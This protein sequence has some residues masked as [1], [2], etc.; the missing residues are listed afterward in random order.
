MTTYTNQT[1]RR[2]ATF[3]YNNGVKPVMELRLSVLVFLLL[4]TYISIIV[5][6]LQAEYPRNARAYGNSIG[7]ML[8]AMERTNTTN[9]RL[10][11]PTKITTLRST[12]RTLRLSYRNP[13]M[14]ILN[15]STNKLILSALTEQLIELMDCFERFTALQHNIDIAV[16]S[17]RLSDVRQRIRNNGSW[18]SIHDL[19]LYDANDN[20]VL[21]R[22]VIMMAVAIAGHP[23]RL[24]GRSLCPRK[25]ARQFTLGDLECF[26]AILDYAPSISNSLRARLEAIVSI[27]N[28]TIHHQSLHVSRVQHYI[29][30][31]AIRDCAR[32]WPSIRSLLDSVI[33]IV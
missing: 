24:Y 7:F 11:K 15:H 12:A 30:L 4:D 16:F 3:L 13:F 10:V 31:T 18:E 29:N 1:L 25:H 14:H 27:R 8:R 2:Q 9:T 23:F 6:M 28:G 33:N 22:H 26:R 17:S 19:I 21:G 20:K 32:K 5:P